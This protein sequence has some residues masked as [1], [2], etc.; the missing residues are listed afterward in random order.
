MTKKRVLIVDDSMVM[1]MMIGDIL[2][3]NDF[4][5]AGVA[6]DGINAMKMYQTLK[7]D[8]VTMDIIMPNELGIESLRK[9]MQ[10]DPNARVVVISGLHQKAL[11]MEA[12]EA[13]AKDYIIKPF[14]EDELLSSLRKISL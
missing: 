5:I 2:T 13:G 11:L 9:I 3:R 6:E 4:E 14:T 8:I 10:Y 12:L 7:P 1:R